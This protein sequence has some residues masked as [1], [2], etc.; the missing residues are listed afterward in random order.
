MVFIFIASLSHAVEIIPNDSSFSFN[1]WFNSNNDLYTPAWNAPKELLFIN[2]KDGN[3]NIFTLT[4][5]EN[6][7]NNYYFIRLWGSENTV[8][9]LVDWDAVMLPGEHMFTFNYD[10]INRKWELYIDGSK[11]TIIWAIGT[12]PAD[13]GGTLTLGPEVIPGSFLYHDSVL[14][15]NQISTL[16]NLGQPGTNAF[17][18]NKLFWE[19]LKYFQNFFG[20]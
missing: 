17:N 19:V 12:M 4:R 3:D 13:I 11:K 14:T 16:K 5:F 7:Y 1:F 15:M 6:T 10:S 9:G 2:R 8:Q 20:E 18:V